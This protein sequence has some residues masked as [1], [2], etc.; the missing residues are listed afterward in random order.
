MTTNTSS[1]DNCIEV[2]LNRRKKLAKISNS[3]FLIQVFA[4]IAGFVV[5]GRYQLAPLTAARRAIIDL[6]R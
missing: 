3:R 2:C 4:K 6:V 5:F 1:V